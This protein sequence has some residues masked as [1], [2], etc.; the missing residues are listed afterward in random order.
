[1]TFRGFLREI[2]GSRSLPD[3]WAAQQRAMEHYGFTRLF[4][5]LTRSRTATSIGDPDDFVIL[6]NFPKAY[7]EPF[8]SRR[9]YRHAPMVQWAL[10][11]DGACSWDTLPELI[12]QAP[13]QEMA[14]R[15]MAFN[16]AHGVTAGYT[17]SFPSNS[18][19][20]KGAIALVP[21]PGVDQAR[22]NDIWA[23]K[24]EDISL[25]NEMAHLKVLSLPH[26]GAANGLTARQREALEWVGD[27]KTSSDIALLMGVSQ[28]TVE[29]HLRLAREVLG[30]ETTAQAVLKAAYANQIFVIRS[31]G[32]T[33]QSFTKG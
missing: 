10:R 20:K 13:D 18:E 24:G 17:L 16:I 14:G 9:L 1:M 3:L 31:A 19:R 30:V 21:P 28:A 22:V 27:G 33:V 26:P 7:R 15:V 12:R 29:K 25:I 11:E 6:T 32:E 8:L 2:T 23:E 4:Y 5:G